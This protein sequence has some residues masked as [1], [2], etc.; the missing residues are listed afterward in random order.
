MS[1]ATAKIIRAA[2]KLTAQEKQEI[3][4]AFDEAQAWAK[5]F[6]LTEQDIKDAIREVRR[7]KRHGKK[8][9]RRLSR[10]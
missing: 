8:V 5:E 9:S 4:A 6:G 10:L 2:P 1:E 3:L 7:E